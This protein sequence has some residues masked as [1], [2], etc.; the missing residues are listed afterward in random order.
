MRTTTAA[1]FWLKNDC[2]LL[3]LSALTANISIHDYNKIKKKPKNDNKLDL[4]KF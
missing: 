4:M 1:M 3:P 2:V